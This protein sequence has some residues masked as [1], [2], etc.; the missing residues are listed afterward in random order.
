M[1][2]PLLAG[3]F[4]SDLNSGADGVHLSGGTKLAADAGKTRLL[5]S[6]VLVQVYRSLLSLSKE[7]IYSKSMMQKHQKE[8]NYIAFI[9]YSEQV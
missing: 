2:P 4:I 3:G 5:F 9:S 1:T 8:R 7:Q 6:L